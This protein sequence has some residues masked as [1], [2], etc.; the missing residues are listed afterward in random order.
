[1]YSVLHTTLY[2]KVSCLKF[3][4][5]KYTY[6]QGPKA[7]I[8]VDVHD[9]YIYTHKCPRMSSIVRMWPNMIA[10]WSTPTSTSAS[11]SWC[12]RF[13]LV[14]AIRSVCILL[15]GFRS[16]SDLSNPSLWGSLASVPS[17]SWSSIY[18]TSLDSSLISRMLMPSVLVCET[19]FGIDF[20]PW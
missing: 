5:E 6:I 12:G 8:R 20:E 15:E 19:L 17:K 9:K 16:Q 2:T 1:M 18:R 11:E 7:R 3:V 4:Y 10:L 13:C 14:S